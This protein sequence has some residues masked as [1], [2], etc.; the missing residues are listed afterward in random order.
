MHSNPEEHDLDQ[1]I[2]VEGIG[3]TKH[4]SQPMPSISP[5]ETGGL[6]V[7]MTKGLYE[8]R[9]NKRAES[10]ATEEAKKEREEEI[11]GDKGHSL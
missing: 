4:N 10:R 7:E 8:T 9:Q 3:I 2:Y 11:G 5:A 6:A 1:F